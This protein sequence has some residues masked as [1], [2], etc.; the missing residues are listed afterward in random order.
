MLKTGKGAAARRGKGRAGDAADRL[1]DR[2]EPRKGSN[3]FSLPS[4]AWFLLQ[5][6]KKKRREKHIFFS[7]RSRDSVEEVFLKSYHFTKCEK[8]LDLVYL[9]KRLKSCRGSVGWMHWKNFR[10]LRLENTGTEC[11]HLEAIAIAQQPRHRGKIV[12]QL[13]RWQH[14]E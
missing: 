11:R 1:D 5:K 12:V 14:V 6:E 13:Y 3:K 7:R 4:L 9:S 2:S 8:S 10:V